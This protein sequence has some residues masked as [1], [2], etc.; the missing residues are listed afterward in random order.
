M[1]RDFLTGL[2]RAPHLLGL[3]AA[4]KQAGGGPITLYTDTIVITASTNSLPS[5]V[6]AVTQADLIGGGESGWGRDDF[7]GAQGG[8]GGKGGSFARKTGTVLLLPGTAFSATIG[9]GGAPIYSGGAPGGISNLGGTTSLTLG[10]WSITAPCGSLGTGGDIH[11]LGGDGGAKGSTT[12]SNAGSGGGTCG[13]PS[14]AGTAGGDSSGSTGG[15]GGLIT[16][17]YLSQG[18]RGANSTGSL[19]ADAGGSGY[20]AGGG[21]A[22]QTTAVGGA[23]ANGAIILTVVRVR[24]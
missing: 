4:T 1:P 6:V 12:G 3:A 7:T 16:T 20:G 10:A 17:P 23:G 13:T 8:A 24:R 2:P 19:P 11:T 15:A 22:G 21:G 18:G 14:G 9:Q 5:D